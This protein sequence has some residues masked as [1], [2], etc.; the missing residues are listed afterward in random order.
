MKNEFLPTIVVFA[1]MVIAVSYA[2]TP[3]WYNIVVI[4][5]G[6]LMM[7]LSGAFLSTRKK[8]DNDD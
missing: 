3:L 8:D 2:P 7:F 6:V 5:S 1:I 4:V